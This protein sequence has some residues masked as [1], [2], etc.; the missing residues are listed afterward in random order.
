MATMEYSKFFF[1]RFF[2]PGPFHK[3]NIISF[4]IVHILT[5]VGAMGNKKETPN[6][7]EALAWVHRAYEV[8]EMKLETLPYIKKS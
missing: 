6:M 4:V 7:L 2:C 3:K 5:L 8:L 1:L